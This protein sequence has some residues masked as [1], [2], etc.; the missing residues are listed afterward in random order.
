ML[1]SRTLARFIPLGGTPL[2]NVAPILRRACLLGSLLVLIHVPSGCAWFFERSAESRAELPDTA[3]AT[4]VP[5][6]PGNTVVI[7]LANRAWRQLDLTVTERVL[8]AEPQTDGALLVQVEQ[9][10]RFPNLTKETEHMSM[11]VYPDRIEYVT[12]D[13]WRETQL[14]TPLRPG[15]RWHFENPEKQVVRK[16]IVAIED[17]CTPRGKFSGAI[18]VETTIASPKASGER[19]HRRIT[20]WFAKGLGEVLVID[21][22]P[23][24]A[25]A[26]RRFF[27]IDRLSADRREPFTP[28]ACSL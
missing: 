24:Q 18:K 10:I 15:T 22:R 12:P 11:A 25:D 5:V 23:G 2:P 1:S 20:R 26:E 13:G 3:I 6:A 14:K 8:S 27:M 17:V 4:F 19:I 21:R 7:R 16:R 9:V 28:P